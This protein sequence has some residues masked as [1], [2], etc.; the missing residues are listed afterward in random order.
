MQLNTKIGLSNIPWRRN[1]RAV[2]IGA[3]FSRARTGNT[4]ETAKVLSLVK[5]TFGI[6]HVKFALT[7][8]SRQ[9][10]VYND[11]PRTLA[12]TAFEDVYCDGS[13]V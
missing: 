9:A 10:D 1:R 3:E 11:G 8:K 2:L 5:D 6:P 7:L 13:N 4:V 12:L